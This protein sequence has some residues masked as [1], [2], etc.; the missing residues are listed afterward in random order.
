[1]KRISYLSLALLFTIL[2]NVAC[3]KSGGGGGGGGGTTPPT[4]RMTAAM[5]YSPGTLTV[6]QNTL[7]NLTNDAGVTH[8]VTSDDG[9]TFDK[10]VAA[11]TTVTYNCPTVGTFP[12]HC[13]FHAGMVGTLIV[14]P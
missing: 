2:L 8:S 12:F 3:S 11:G 9:T 6:K 4:L 10:D 13:K 5:A 1:M 7:I 14:T